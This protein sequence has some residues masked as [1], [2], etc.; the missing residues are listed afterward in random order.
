MQS[1]MIDGIQLNNTMTQEQFIYWIQG[2]FEINGSNEVTPR[3]IQIIKDHLK[4]VFEKKTPDYTGIRFDPIPAGTT[5]PWTCDQWINK[6]PQ[7]DNYK[8]TCSAGTVT[9]NVPF[10]C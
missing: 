3:Q 5:I 1:V 8:V 10:I 6:Y 7:D 2:F 4:L 9:N